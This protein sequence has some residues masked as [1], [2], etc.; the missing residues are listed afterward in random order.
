MGLRERHKA[1]T[2][3]QIIGAAR[4]LI[5][6]RGPTGW[7]MRDLA[8]AADVSLR[9]PYNLFGSKAEVLIA[10]LEEIVDA[11]DATASA[12]ETLDPI[13]HAQALIEISVDRFVAEDGFLGLVVKALQAATDDPQP[14]TV[15]KGG[16]SAMEKALLAARESGMITDDACPRLLAR[17]VA[18][19]FVGAL[20]LWIHEGLTDDAFRAQCHY[21]LS[22]CLLA[23]GSSRARRR[24]RE[25]MPALRHRLHEAPATVAL[26]G[27]D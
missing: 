19:S 11:L 6:E 27:T 17:H 2:K 3:R 22:I 9:T 20:Q 8:D 24:V 18:L 12:L 10:L 25:Q 4:A 13:E 7:G 26:T 14:S 5:R 15:L 16:A 21:G 23:V 1:R